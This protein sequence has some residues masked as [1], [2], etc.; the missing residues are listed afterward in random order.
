LSEGTT[1]G[2]PEVRINRTPSRSSGRPSFLDSSYLAAY[3]QRNG[4]D[5]FCGRLRRVASHICNSARKSNIESL[6]AFPFVFG[7]SR[8]RSAFQSF[9]CT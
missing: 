2:L 6:L 3:A 1:Q 7:L 4:L 5:R 8:G 9:G